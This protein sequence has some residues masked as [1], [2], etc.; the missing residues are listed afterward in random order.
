MR[1]IIYLILLSSIL[2]ISITAQ[3]IDCSVDIVTENLSQDHTTNLESFKTKIMDYINSNKFSDLDWEGPKIP[4]NISIQLIPI[5]TRNYTANMFVAAK[6]T[7]SEEDDEAAVA[8]MFEDIGKWNFEY[9]SGLSLSFDYNRYD[10]LSSILDFYMLIIIGLDLDS[11]EELSGD[12]CFRRAKNIFDVATSRNAPGWGSFSDEYGKHT[13]ISDLMSLR[14]AGFR[15]LVLEYYLDGLELLKTN[16]AEALKN[17]AS[18]I[19]AMA[20][21]KERYINPSH[22][23]DAWFFAKCNELCDL[24]RGYSDTRIF[25]N[26]MY[27][28]P[29]NTAKYEAAKDNKK[30]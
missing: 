19:S 30:R 24:F 15:K 18:T 4:V 11:Y 23:M 27:L 16:R 14:L 6:R 21:F 10:N 12:V 2:T 20:D 3:E 29:T 25:R 7:I 1:K 13:L 5:G 26:L 17:I 28:D 9:S 22:Y 8:I